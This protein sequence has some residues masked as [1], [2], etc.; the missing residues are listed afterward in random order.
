MMVFSILDHER[1][2]WRKVRMRPDDVIW[3]EEAS[4]VLDQEPIRLEFAWGLSKVQNAVCITYK[5]VRSLYLPATTPQPPLA[6]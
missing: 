6:L 5:V 2:K 4:K 3:I 1:L